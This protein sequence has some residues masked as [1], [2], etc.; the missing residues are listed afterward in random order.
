M[1]VRPSAPQIKGLSK[2]EEA[3]QTLAPSKTARAEAASGLWLAELDGNGPLRA[4]PPGM[5]HGYLGDWSK[6]LEG[7]KTAREPA[8][9]SEAVV[10]T[11]EPGFVA[12]PASSTVSQ[13]VQETQLSV[14]DLFRCVSCLW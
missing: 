1:M 10:V 6:G 4:V 13:P 12:P 9:Q 5:S 2:F 3:E 14:Q 8:D 7:D 11:G